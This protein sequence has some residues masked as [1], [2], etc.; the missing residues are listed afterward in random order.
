M[1]RRQRK[2]EKEIRA[3]KAAEE[4]IAKEEAQK[5]KRKQQREAEKKRRA[6][7][8]PEQRKKEDKNTALGC[9]ALLLLILLIGGCGTFFSSD[10]KSPSAEQSSTV[11][12]ESTTSDAPEQ[13]AQ[14]A[15]ASGDAEA[16]LKETFGVSSWSEVLAQDPTMWAGYINGSEVVGGMWHIRLQV[17]RNADTELAERAAKAIASL[18]RAAKDDPRVSGIDWVIIED[19]A[20]VF[21]A[22]ESI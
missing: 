4:K 14:N 18:A 13:P 21:M 15:A 8:T 1:S 11:Y 6:S 2:I 16:W 20:G 3:R 5:A 19:G 9:G 12:S 22:Q 17:D 10:N 7:L